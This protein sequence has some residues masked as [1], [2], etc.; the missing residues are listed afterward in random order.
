MIFH[1]MFMFIIFCCWFS[2][3]AI[4]IPY[5]MTIVMS[6]PFPCLGRGL[7]VSGSRPEMIQKRDRNFGLFRKDFFRGV[8]VTTLDWE[9]GLLNH[10]CKQLH[11][12]DDS[13]IIS[14]AT[15]ISL[16]M[17]PAFDQP[18]EW[19]QYKMRAKNDTPFWKATVFM[20]CPRASAVRFSLNDPIARSKWNFKLRNLWLSN[21]LI[22]LLI[23]KEDLHSTIND[24]LYGF[25]FK[26]YKSP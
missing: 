24:V 12:K 22:L 20:D 11:G 2:W 14:Q 9:R 5:W 3:K 10:Y 7:A 6:F 26:L 1:S 19:M 8:K 17:D 21:A 13:E 23:C 15:R 18:L 4:M 25:L 16:K